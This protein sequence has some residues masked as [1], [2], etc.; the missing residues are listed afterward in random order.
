MTAFKI[1]CVAGCSDPVAV[2]T[3]EPVRCSACGTKYDGVTVLSSPLPDIDAGEEGQR[4]AVA[5][6]PDTPN[7]VTAEPSGIEDGNLT[8]DVNLNVE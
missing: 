7:A 5:D 4:V 3:G 2:E 1:A 8:I 6:R